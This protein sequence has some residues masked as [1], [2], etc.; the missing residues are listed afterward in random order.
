VLDKGAIVMEGPPA[1]V[2]ADEP[3]MLQHG[4]ETP[5]LLRHRHPH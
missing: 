3:R 5:H 4:L 1:E 2:L